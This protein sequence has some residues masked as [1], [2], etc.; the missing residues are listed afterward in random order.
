[1]HLR[2]SLGILLVG[3]GLA[4]GSL[5]GQSTSALRFDSF[6][7]EPTAGDRRVYAIA[8]AAWWND[9]TDVTL[10][11]RLRSIHGRTDRITAWLSRGFFGVEHA[12]VGDVVD[13]YL[14]WENPWFLNSS[15]ATQSLELWS[16]DGTVGARVVLDRKS[17][18]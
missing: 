4:P 15:D 6:F 2:L 1:M 8:P 7:S 5:S 10:A 13:G 3:L 17:V 11:I 14:K 12:T 9:A 16:Q 18:V